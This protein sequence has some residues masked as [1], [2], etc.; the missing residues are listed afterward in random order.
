MTEPTRRSVTVCVGLGAVASLLAA[1]S[2]STAAH[3]P[4]SDSSP[5]TDVRGLLLAVDAVSA[6]DVWA[7]GWHDQHTVIVH[8][9][10]M[11]W[12]QVPSPNPG[13]LK[14]SMLSGVAGVSSSDAW[15]VG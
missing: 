1:A 5:G 4:P 14:P 7:V 9:D 10:G 8:W 6:S 15:A 11:E 12:T 3:A 2:T 13:G